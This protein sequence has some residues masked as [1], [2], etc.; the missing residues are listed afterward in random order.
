M[1]TTT[2]IFHKVD[3]FQ[4]IPF[5]SKQKEQMKQRKIHYNFYSS[6]SCQM[7]VEEPV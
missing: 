6:I 4:R 2:D 1:L 7:R 5:F 3:D